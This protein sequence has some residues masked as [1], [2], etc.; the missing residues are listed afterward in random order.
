MA[1]TKGT[2]GGSKQVTVVAVGRRPAGGKAQVKVSGK[3]LGASK[4][5]AN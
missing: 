3:L 2:G 5:A 4:K 1:G